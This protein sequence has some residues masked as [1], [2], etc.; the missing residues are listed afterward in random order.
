MQLVYVW[1]F[2]MFVKKQIMKLIGG[3][4]LTIGIIMAFY[5]LRMDTFIHNDVPLI[6]DI[7]IS[8][9]SLIRQ[10]QNY[11]IFAGFLAIIGV[12]LLVVDSRNKAIIQAATQTTTNKEMST[13]EK[14]DMYRGYKIIGVIVLII[15]GVFV[16]FGLIAA[17]NK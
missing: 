4:I 1:F 5:A 7:K 16:V 6:G 14:Q 10:Q 13:Q 8:N 15:V 3:L 9:G 2:C 11:F 12:V 17:L